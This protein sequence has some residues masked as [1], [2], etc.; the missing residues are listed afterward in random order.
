MPPKIGA[1]FGVEAH[2][3][4]ASFIQLFC[5]LLNGVQVNIQVDFIQTKSQLYGQ[6]QTG[7]AAFQIW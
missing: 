2:P 4:A 6:I 3:N 7:F 1:F 5:C